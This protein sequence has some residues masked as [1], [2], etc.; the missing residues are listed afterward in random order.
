MSRIA[1]VILVLAALA[2]GLWLGFNPRMHAQVVQTWNQAR[3]S[4]THLMAQVHL[5]PA[6]KLK[7]N[8]TARVESPN[9]STTWRQITTA[10]ESLLS[11]LQHF[12]RNVTARI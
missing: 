4:W 3:A 1:V 6:A 8:P 7:V 5:A 12:W 9:L 2:V 11:N 10:F